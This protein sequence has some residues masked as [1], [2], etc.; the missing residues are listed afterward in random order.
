MIWLIL[1]ITGHDF[2]S[3]ELLSCERRS[4]SIITLIACETFFFAKRISEFLITSVL[5]S[6]KM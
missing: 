2:E 1:V 3:C 4:K 6:A 5:L